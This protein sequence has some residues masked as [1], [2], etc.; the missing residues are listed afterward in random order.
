M[1]VKNKPVSLSD[2]SNAV[3]AS[4]A[5]ATDEILEALK[6]AIEDVVNCLSAIPDNEWL[7]P[8]INRRMITTKVDFCGSSPCLVP[9]GFGLWLGSAA[10]FS[11]VQPHFDLAV[12]P[13]LTGLINAKVSRVCARDMSA[14]LKNLRAT[15]PKVDSVVQDT[16]GDFAVPPLDVALKWKK[17]RSE[18]SCEDQDK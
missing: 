12:F 6:P 1:E 11:L 16:V 18:P 9:D 17:E 13:E 15:L 14:W 8:N 5:K 4:N 2:F 7:A 3:F 10:E